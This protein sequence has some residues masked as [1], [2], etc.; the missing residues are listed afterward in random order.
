MRLTDRGVIVL[1]L[2]AAAALTVMLAAGS[3]V[4]GVG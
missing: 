4:L 3:P 2:L 1:A